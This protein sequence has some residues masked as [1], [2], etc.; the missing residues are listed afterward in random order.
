MAMSDDEL[1]PSLADRLEWVACSLLLAGDPPKRTVVWE[2]VEE[3]RKL[4]ARYGEDWEQLEK[5][6]AP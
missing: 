4:H 2:A 3:L 5:E 6:G 1:A